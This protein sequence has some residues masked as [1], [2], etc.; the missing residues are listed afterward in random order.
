[1]AL[2]SD[3]C[4]FES[5]F[6]VS[7]AVCL[8]SKVL[9]SLAFLICQTEGHKSAIVKS[10]TLLLIVLASVLYHPHSEHRGWGG[11]GVFMNLSPLWTVVSGSHPSP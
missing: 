2:R 7:L 8:L 4:G 6:S 10:R 11:E 9:S 3:R 1:M 5:H